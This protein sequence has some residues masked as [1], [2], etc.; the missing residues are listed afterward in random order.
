MNTPN[1]VTP[2]AREMIRLSRLAYAAPADIG[3]ELAQGAHGLQGW[4]LVWG[5]VLAR[6]LLR[7]IDNLMF[8][9]QKGAGDDAELAVTI[10]GTTSTS[11]ESWADDLESFRLE[12]WE[13]AGP[14]TSNPK[15]SRG[16]KHVFDQMTSETP[17][18]A[19]SRGT[20]TLERFLTAAGVKK[21]HVTGHS[22]GGATSSMM[23]A[24]VD[25]VLRKAGLGDG[26]AVSPCTFAG[27]SAGNAG[28]AED[29]DRRFRGTWRYANEHD[30]VPRAWADLRAIDTI[31][32]PHVPTPDWLEVVLEAVSLATRH[33]HYT[34]PNGAGCLL[35]STVST[36][37]TFV[38]EVEHQH[39][40]DT[41][42]ALM[43]AADTELGTKSAAS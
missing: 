17:T 30:I 18:G 39:A 1:C 11:V 35:P 12:P 26:L 14:G 13:Y 10:R 23:A 3:S 41:Y 28:F 40:A 5:P 38:A 25:T 29:L 36:P 31:Y 6:D 43:A 22:Q 16:L 9:A 32:D 19:G 27:E 42:I 24:Y 8:V 7:Q 21:I 37:S 2:S 34:Q 15:V 4:S 33:L 20:G